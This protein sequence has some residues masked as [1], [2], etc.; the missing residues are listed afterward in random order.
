MPLQVVRLA[1]PVVAHML[2]STLV[3]VVSRAMLGRHSSVSLGSMQLS[4]PLLWSLLSICT[5]FS[6]GVLAMVGRCQGAG[7]VQMAAT[8]ARLGL[9]VALSLGVVVA[10]PLS[11][12]LPSLLAAV[13]PEAGEEVRA[14]AVLYMRAVLVTLP[15]QFVETVAAATLQASGDTRTPM[16]VGILVNV[17]HILLGPGLLFGWA[18]LPEWGVLGAGVGASL[19]L[20]LEGALLWWALSRRGSPLDLR[21]SAPARV[22]EA[23]VRL[24]R[25]SVPA[26]LEKLAYHV[27]FLTYVGMIASLGPLV[28][29][30]NQALIGLESLC[31]LTAEGFGIAAGALIPR[32]LGAGA[33]E[34]AEQAGWWATGMAGGLML[35]VGSVYA[36]GAP[37][38]LP[39]MS[40]DVR[41][42]ELGA[43]VM[44]VMPVLEPL[45]SVAMVLTMGMRGAGAT[46]SV[47]LV[48]LSC[49]LGVRV[50][51][52]FALTRVWPLGL[53]G[54]WLGALADWAARATVAVWMFRRGRWKTL[55]V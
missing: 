4:G 16:R 22:R 35:V 43:R 53:W 30:A 42:V 33:P 29:A 11:V 20:G 6:T 48:T 40:S 9:R 12:V 47:L 49:A 36:L 15:L 39:W 1:W 14:S 8:V 18:G 38:F 32:R 46:R 13:F 41:I 51:A 24:W 17:L 34:A 52:T 44:W 45:M 3:F 28:M 37:V 27:G 2:L 7:D 23:M 5:A 10:L 26:I 21:R 50:V 19:A 25:V 55:R 31:F 54:V